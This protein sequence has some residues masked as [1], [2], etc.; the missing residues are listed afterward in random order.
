MSTGSRS[1]ITLPRR[2][3]LGN[4]PSSPVT[5]M[6]LLRVVGLAV[7]SMFWPLLLAVVVI[8]PQSERPL[9]VLLAFYLGDFLTATVR[10]GRPPAASQYRRPTNEVPSRLIGGEEQESRPEWLR[11]Y[12]RLLT[13]YP[14]SPRSAG[15]SLAK[16]GRCLNLGRVLG[17]NAALVAINLRSLRRGAETRGLPGVWSS[18]TILARALSSSRERISSG[19]V[20]TLLWSLCSRAGSPA[21]IGTVRGSVTTIELIALALATAIRPTSL[22]AVYALLSSAG[23]RRLMSAYVLAGLTFTIAFGLLVV[24]VFNGASIQSGQQNAGHRG[25]RWRN[26]RPQ[27]RCFGADRS[28]RRTA[29]RRRAY[30][31]GTL[32]Q[33]ARPPPHGRDPPPSRGRRPMSPACST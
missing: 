22:A 21:R 25:D 26:P 3:I 27:L 18:L 9:R 1:E 19:I 7:A 20:E 13:A 24:G 17:A 10:S 30:G 28:R 29:R 8:P 16:G 2:R 32:E 31:S 11:S 5:P 23:P 14:D 33:A 12:A 6:L 4:R 15:V